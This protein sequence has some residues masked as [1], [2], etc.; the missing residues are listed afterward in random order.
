M[1]HKA[2]LTISRPSYG[3][4]RKKISIQVRDINARIQFLEL[5]IDL[6]KFTECLTGLSEVESDMEFRGLENV[7]KSKETMKIEFEIPDASYITGKDKVKEIAVLNT[8][9]GWTCSSYFSSQNSFFQKDD[10][11]FARTTASRWVEK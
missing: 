3:D 11:Y 2:A 1:K 9:E 7:G 6:D 10:K 8:P 5:E 4:D